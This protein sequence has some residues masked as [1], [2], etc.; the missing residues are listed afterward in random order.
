MPCNLS[1]FTVPQLPSLSVVERHQAS[2]FVFHFVR[3]DSC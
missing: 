1:M 3:I 2:D